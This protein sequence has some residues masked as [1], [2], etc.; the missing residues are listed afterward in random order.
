[1]SL[2]MTGHI[3]D[4]FA[5]TPVIVKAFTAGHRDDFGIWVPGTSIDEVYTATTQ[6]LRDRELDNLL[7]AGKRILDSRKIYINSGDLEK[8]KLSNDV[9]FLGQLWEIID[10]DIR[11]WRTYAKIVVSRYDEQP[12]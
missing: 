11:P 4:V 5:S 3:D 9:E 10:S 2:D 1:M 8:L 6:P 12:T 7:R